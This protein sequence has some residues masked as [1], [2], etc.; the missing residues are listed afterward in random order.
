M[1]VRKT[2][3][4]FIKELKNVNPYIKP[5]EDYKGAKTKILVECL[6]D[7]YRWMAAP[8]NLLQGKGCRECKRMN[9][10]TFKIKNNED[11]VKILHQYNKENNTYWTTDDVYIGSKQKMHFYCEKDNFHIYCIASNL[12]NGFYRCKACE[13]KFYEDRLKQHIIN[14]NL[15]IIIKGNYEGSD[16]PIKC[17]C[18]ICG[19]EYFTLPN[20]ILE[21]NAICRKCAYVNSGL[22]SRVKIDEF[23][24]RLKNNNPDIT[25]L[26]GYEGMSSYVLVKCN[27]CGYV[28]RTLASL[29]ANTDKGCPKCNFSKGE[30]RI[31]N[32]LEINNIK[33]VPQKTFDN[34]RATN[35][36]R[37]DFY[38]PQYNYLIEYQG[39]QHEKIIDFSGRG[40]E[41]AKIQFE[42]GV[43]NDNKKRKFASDNK[44]KLIE[45]WYYDFDNIEKILS[46][47]FHI[48]A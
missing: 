12:L 9:H 33:Y 47:E 28:W 32:F 17:I 48:A 45:I 42:N 24:E 38:I 11:F 16:K 23:L 21:S 19:E 4:D 1:F 44:I 3:D 37:Y 20:R 26:S 40:F 27:K 29:V 31:S 46:N 14:N 43:R 2:N 15:P 5:L 25:Y 35:K 6:I 13:Q 7:G 36:L 41:Y 10:S 30:K 34:L 18:K 8:T 22:N 39:I